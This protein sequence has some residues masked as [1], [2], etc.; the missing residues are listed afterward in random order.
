M[1]SLKIVSNVSSKKTPK[2]I[3]DDGYHCIVY[4]DGL[5][6]LRHYHD[7]GDI[8]IFGTLVFAPEISTIFVVDIYGFNFHCF[9]DQTEFNTIHELE[10]NAHGITRSSINAVI[11]DLFQAFQAFQAF[12]TISYGMESLNAA[13]KSYTES[14]ADQ[15]PILANIF[16]SLVVS[17]IM[18]YQL[19]K[20]VTENPYIPFRPEVFELDPNDHRSAFKC[21]K[22]IPLVRVFIDAIDE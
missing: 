16:P 21:F 7:D 20:W 4:S 1:V 19:S 14:I 9:E 8:F 5:M 11:L 2:G 17:K 15:S 13:R 18:N 22:D 12:T 6:S 3:R 10:T